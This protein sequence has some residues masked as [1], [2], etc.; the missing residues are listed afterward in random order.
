LPLVP[1]LPHSSLHLHSLSLILPPKS[2]S[3]LYFSWEPTLQL[4][5]L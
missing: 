2:L 3:F 4:L 1:F 5:F